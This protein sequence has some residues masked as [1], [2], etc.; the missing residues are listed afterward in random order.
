MLGCAKANC[1]SKKTI[2]GLRTLTLSIWKGPEAEG[3]LVVGLG[4]AGGSEMP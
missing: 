1:R 4:K 2:V 3:G